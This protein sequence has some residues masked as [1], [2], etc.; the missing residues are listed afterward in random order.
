M[1]AKL[2][3]LAQSFAEFPLLVGTSRKLFIGRLL[4]DAPADERL[5]GTMA[6]VTAAILRGAHI[7]RV[8]DVK[9]A[10]ETARIA[11]AIIKASG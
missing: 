5:Y 4:N 9:A 8:H 6:T 10:H 2:D 1:I 11:D 7:V 3:Q